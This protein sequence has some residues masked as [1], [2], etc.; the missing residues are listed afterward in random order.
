MI[1]HLIGRPSPSWKRAQVFLVLFFWVWRIVWGNPTGPRVLFLR[2]ANRMLQRFTPWQIVVSTLT[3]VYALRNLDKIL[4]LG[5]PEPLARLYS[6]SY[7]RATWISTGMDAGFATAMAIR[8]RW[9]RDICSILFSA[10]YILYANEADEKLRR[11]RAVPTVEMLRATWEKTSNPY[12]RLFVNKKRIAYYRKILL[13]RPQSSPYTRPITVHIYFSPRDTSTQPEDP[14]AALA[15][16]EDLILDIPGGGFVAMTPEHHEERLRM[17]AIRT[18]KPVVSVEYGKAPEHPYPFAVDE[19]FDA[20]RV[21]VESKGEAIGMSGKA[22]NVIVSGDSAGATIAVGV[23]VKT[24]EHALS[25]S[26]PASRYPR[27]TSMPPQPLPLPVALVLNYAAL[28]FNFTS[29]MTPSNLRV[30][31]IET[32]ADE[33]RPRTRSPAVLKRQSSSYFHGSDGEEDEP[34]SWASVL[35]ETKDHLSHVSPLAVVGDEYKRLKLRRKKSWGDT[36]KLSLGSA[37]TSPVA[38]TRGKIARRQRSTGE[39]LKHKQSLASVTMSRSKTETRQGPG[40][41]EDTDSDEDATVFDH[42]REE[43]RPLEARIRW[44]FTPDHTPLHTPDASEGAH[45]DAF[46]PSSRRNTLDAA[47]QAKLQDAISEADNRAIDQRKREGVQR[48]EAPI[49][50]RLTMTSR[51]G[52]FQDR[53]ISPSM[54]RAMAILYIGPHLNPD[55]ATDYHISPIL[56]PP[57]LLAQF[58]PLLMQCGEK[59]PFVDDT[60]IFAGRV[61]EAKRQR[62]LELRQA[63][64]TQGALD[65]ERR[66]QMQ[67]EL[68]KLEGEMEED[69]VQLQLYSDWSHGYLQMPTLMREARTA[70]NDIA[71]WIDN[72]FGASRALTRSPKGVESG[73]SRTPARGGPVSTAGQTI[74]E[75]ELMRRR[76]LLDSHIFASE[77]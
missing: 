35:R 42:L 69:W 14:V 23:M 5:A 19:A 58:P 49:G 3:T 51:T 27:P 46:F 8:P 72:A 1:D 21:L 24:L 15:M 32:E 43:E 73:R 37:A 66:Q 28:D 9:L 38:T 25:V 33:H 7:Y 53:I 60:I 18:G 34:E 44:F 74:S 70:I 61:R 56:T 54:M 20:Y 36:L 55:F 47:E 45:G 10:Y 22:F 11:F 13:P 71:D 41:D 57:Q 77:S 63:I 76:R 26:D 4:G 39:M 40:E 48:K 17:W 30:L 52:Y 2:R 6:P 67:R 62:K 75:S 68:E 12:I 31:R 16:Q 64:R 29:W 65:E 59:D 50:T